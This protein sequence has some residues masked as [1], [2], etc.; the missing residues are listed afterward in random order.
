MDFRC[1]SVHTAIFSFV[2]LS[3]DFC[4]FTDFFF[5]LLSSLHFAL[6]LRFSLF[7]I[8][9]SV[10]KFFLYFTFISSHSTFFTH[11]TTLFFLD[12][13]VILSQ[14]NVLIAEYGNLHRFFCY[15]RKTAEVTGKIPFNVY[16]AFSET[17]KIVV[18]NL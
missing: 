15:L 14:I 4:S 8:D 18:A 2:D 13:Y 5:F 12:R 3:T 7:K 11:L 1:G 10:L 16:F 17:N 9:F 6:V